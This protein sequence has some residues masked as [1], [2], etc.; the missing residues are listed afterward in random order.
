MDSDVTSVSSDE[1]SDVSSICEDDIFSCTSST[2]SASS[3]E[4]DETSTRTCTANH[5]A[6]ITSTGTSKH[7]V[8]GHSTTYTRGT[9]TE[10]IVRT[11]SPETEHFDNHHISQ[12]ELVFDNINKT[13]TPRFQSLESPR[14][15]LNYINMF[16][17]KDRAM[18]PSHLSRV[19]RYFNTSLSKVEVAKAILP[20]CED[21]KS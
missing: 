12:Y 7:S 18:P 17:F 6:P 13:V 9:S 21:D 4:D 15:T 1:D 16:A 3:D 5:D 11:P 14:L 20:T 2:L 19:S 10:D 8:I